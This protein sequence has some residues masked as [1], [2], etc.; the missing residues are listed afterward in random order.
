MVKTCRSCGSAVCKIREELFCFRC[1]EIKN[2]EQVDHEDIGALLTY[3][4]SASTLNG[5]DVELMND[6]VE[7][8]HLLYQSMEEIVEA[9]GEDN[10]D[11]RRRI[12]W[13]M[14][15]YIKEAKGEKGT[16]RAI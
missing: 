5:D 3:W 11:M 10:L 14:K 16:S 7:H 2:P 1:K 13:F 9:I 8:L 12:E 15:Y 4:Q 6:T